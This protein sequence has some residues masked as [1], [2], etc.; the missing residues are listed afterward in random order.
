MVSFT[1]GSLSFTN[2]GLITPNT[3]VPATLSEFENVFASGMSVRRRELFKGYQTYL[4]HLQAI[5]GNAPFI[6][7]VDGSFTTLTPNP[8]DIDV[9]SFVGFDVVAR[10]EPQLKAL[11]YPHS[12]DFGVDAYIVR[13]YPA[14]HRHYPQYTGDRAYWMSQFD[15]TE[16]NRRGIISPKGFLELSFPQ[17]SV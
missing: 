1:K 4:T 7:W 14:D 10:C 2:R 9:V 12:L 6:Q 8:K 13:V 3:N 16:R 11:K 17:I 15:K 5:L